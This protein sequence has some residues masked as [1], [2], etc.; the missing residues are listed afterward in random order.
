[1]KFFF[2]EHLKCFSLLIFIVIIINLVKYIENYSLFIFGHRNKIYK[3]FIN[4]VKK[5][6]FKN[7]LNK[8]F[9]I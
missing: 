1:M 6:K 2:Y 9:I 8:I 5:I 4:I 7:Y 3:S